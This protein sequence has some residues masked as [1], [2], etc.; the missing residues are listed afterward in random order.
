LILVSGWNIYGQASTH[1][2][3]D[4]I[5]RKPYTE[6]WHIQSE[7]CDLEV[8][9]AISTAL[10]GKQ[11]KAVCYASFFNTHTHTHTEEQNG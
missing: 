3:Y 1:L 11:G 10:C 9:T 7:H 4:I 2:G 6:G 8:Y 5:N